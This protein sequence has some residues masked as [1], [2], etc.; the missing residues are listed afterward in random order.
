MS[1]SVIGS[2]RGWTVVAAG[3]GINLALGVLYAWSVI[4]KA[5]PQSWGWSEAEKA[6]PYTIACLT[7]AFM[8][9]PAGRL[10]D[11][12]GPRI[13]ASIGGVLVGIGMIMAS[14]FTSVAMFIV[15]FGLLAGTGIGFGYASATP[16]AIKWFPPAK[17]G[18]IAGLVVAGFGLASVYIAPSVKFMIGAVGLQKTMLILGG[19]FF[20]IVVGL[21]QLLINPPTVAAP[22]PAA[23]S[24]PAASSNDFAPM[25]L[26][27]T[28]QFFFLWIMYAI[29]AGAGLMVI[30]KL[31]GV[32]KAQAASEAGFILV[33]LLAVG[34]AGGRVVAGT[35]SDKLGRIRT[36]QIFAV[37]QALLMFATPFINSLAVL[38]IFSMLIGASYGSNLAVFPSITKDFFGIKNFGVNYG[39]VFTSW[40]VGS[41]MALVSG[42]IK[43]KTGSFKLAFFIAGGLLIF[44]ILLSFVIKKP[45]KSA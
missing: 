10:Q 12:L 11:K 31:A 25:E 42:I 43:D 33:A 44:S 38:V 13:V 24:A 1:D 29:N 21:A 34:N 6:L 19:A 4:S 28:P 14:F 41:L 35:F 5:I 36:L 16:P 39:L 3:I 18:M 9:V 40:G 45:E 17:T 8:M 23:G 22:K 30:G 26:F 7:F 32:V 15:F 2:K 37:L 20:V 27:K